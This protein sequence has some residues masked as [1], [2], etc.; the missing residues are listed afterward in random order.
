MTYIIHPLQGVVFWT[1]VWLYMSVHL[2]RF[3]VLFKDTLTYNQEEPGLKLFYHLS[4]C[5]NFI[6]FVLTARMNI[7]MLKCR[8]IPLMS[9]EW[10]YRI[11]FDQ[12]PIIR[13]GAQLHAAVLEVEGEMQHNNFTVALKDS[14]RVPCDHSSVLQQHFGL[15]NNGKVSICTVG[16]TEA[17]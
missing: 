12:V 3:G 17:A 2:W 8:T 16:Q 11:D 15:M 7:F 5:P 10:N 4:Y 9:S 14:R 13:P 1:A 6:K